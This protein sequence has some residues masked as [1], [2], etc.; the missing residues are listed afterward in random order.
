[1]GISEISMIGMINKV[2]GFEDPKHF[3][4][5]TPSSPIPRRVRRL[6][7]EENGHLRL[8][9]IDLFNA[10]ISMHRALNYRVN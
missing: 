4:I 6:K 9:G 2:G 5:L 3:P 1:M 10:L 7:S 8:V